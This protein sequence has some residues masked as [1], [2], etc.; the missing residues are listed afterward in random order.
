M[1]L[2]K[3]TKYLKMRDRNVITNLSLL[4]TIIHDSVES[5]YVKLWKE[6]C[7]LKCKK[8]YNAFPI[9]FESLNI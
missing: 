6:F 4:V 2:I 5:E 3:F 7:S 9:I 1:L 8:F